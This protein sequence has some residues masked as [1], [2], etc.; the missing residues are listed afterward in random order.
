M[1]Q[2]SLC[3]QGQSP[4][5]AGTE[6]VPCFFFMTAPAFQ[7]NVTMCNFSPLSCHRLPLMWSQ[8]TNQVSGSQGHF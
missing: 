4:C 8:S 5:S 6:S 1:R 3:L 7:G 2:E